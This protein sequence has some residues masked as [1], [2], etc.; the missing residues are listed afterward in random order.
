MLNALPD[1]RAG[2]EPAWAGL[3]YPADTRS[4]NRLPVRHHLRVAAHR[5]HLLPP[6][7]QPPPPDSRTPRHGSLD[8]RP[9]SSLR[10]KSVLAGDVDHSPG[11]RLLSSGASSYQ[12]AWLT[13][14][15]TAHWHAGASR[16]KLVATNSIMLLLNSKRS[17]GAGDGL[18][19]RY[20]NLGNIGFRNPIQAGCLPLLCVLYLTLLKTS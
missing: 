18:R 17:G 14:L 9:I 15:P 12:E 8:L 3:R 10:D 13:P 2:A 5:W 19:T 7:A 1:A 6:R 20:L 4:R 11:A 16:P